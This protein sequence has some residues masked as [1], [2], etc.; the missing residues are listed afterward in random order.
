ML[1]KEISYC[2]RSNSVQV[3]VLK[4]LSCGWESIRCVKLD[5]GSIDVDMRCRGALR[6]G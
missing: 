3:R 2:V 5:L 6:P 1:Y 4:V